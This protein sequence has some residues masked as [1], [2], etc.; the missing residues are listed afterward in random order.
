MRSINASKTTAIFSIGL[1]ALIGAMDHAVGDDSPPSPQLDVGTSI[2]VSNF[3]NWRLK[4]CVVAQTV[5]NGNRTLKKLDRAVLGLHVNEEYSTNEDKAKVAGFTAHIQVLGYGTAAAG[6]A[7]YTLVYYKPGS[8]DKPLVGTQG[9]E[10]LYYVHDAAL[11]N[12]SI[13]GHAKPVPKFPDSIFQPNQPP[14]GV[15]VS[16][17]AGGSRTKALAAK[18]LPNAAKVPSAAVAPA[19]PAPAPGP[20]VAELQKQMDSVTASI[21]QAQIDASHVVTTT[22]KGS[23]GTGDPGGGAGPQDPSKGADPAG[24]KGPK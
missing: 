21:L 5:K 10:G 24:G 19:V 2:E 7:G 23:T 14:A 16:A 6:L 9:P 20:L 8:F 11:N 22:G 3:S 13:S 12:L 1:I 17:G 4:D 15:V 18:G